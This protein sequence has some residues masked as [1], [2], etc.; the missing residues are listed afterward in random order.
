MTDQCA[1]CLQK[2][3]PLCNHHY[4]VTKADG[5][6]ETV[7]ICHNCHGRAHTTFLIDAT[8]ARTEEEFEAIR[9][10]HLDD[11]AREMFPGLWQQGYPFFPAD[12][13][14]TVTPPFMWRGLTDTQKAEA[15][16][17][18]ADAKRH[19]DQAHGRAR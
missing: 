14:I 4:P 11:A 19:Y 10:S 15:E 6:T 16:E 12:R 9:A 5:G 7:R 13:V 3:S 1:W 17:A 18:M 2:G 8:N